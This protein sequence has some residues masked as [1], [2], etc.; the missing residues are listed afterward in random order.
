MLGSADRKLLES[1]EARI[2][3]L[4]AKFDGFV[5]C[6]MSLADAAKYLRVSKGFLYKLTSRHEIPFH[7]PHGKLI[8]FLKQDLDAWALRNRSKSTEEILSNA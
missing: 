2:D 5:V 1:M 3:S 6:I 4:V 8:Y 7:K